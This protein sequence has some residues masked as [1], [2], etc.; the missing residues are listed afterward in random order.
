MQMDEYQVTRT[1]IQ[2]GFTE[3]CIVEIVLVTRNPDGSLN[4][5][6]M[7]V[8]RS[9]P[10]LLIQPYKT[11]QTYRNL[12]RGGQ[13]SINITDD[14]LLFLA[15]AFK[16]ELE[17]DLAFKENELEAASAV[18]NTEVSEQLNETELCASFSLEPREFEVKT[19]HPTVFSRGR[20]EAIEAIIHAT[21]IHVFLN[22]DPMKVQELVRKLDSCLNVINRVSSEGSPEATT[23]KKLLSLMEK[24]GVA[25]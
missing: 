16:A 5:A 10:T 2:L 11:S 22:K 6:P 19:S 23:A 25:T 24:W 4:A 7:G 14:P 3:D 8:K 17:H 18:I 13:A 12:L 9:G 21:R 15:T 20:S 1:L